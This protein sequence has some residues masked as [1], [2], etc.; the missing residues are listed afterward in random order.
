MHAAIEPIWETAENAIEKHEEHLKLMMAKESY[1][2]VVAEAE[3]IMVGFSTL[4]LSKRPEVFLKK[5]SASIQETYV[6]SEYRKA[7]IGKQ[8]AQALISIAREKG[9]EMITLNVAVDNE[10]GNIFWKEM[11][12]R[13]TV[14]QM[15]MYLV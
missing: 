1:H 9:V 2:I 5:Q 4:S 11:G 10:V 14:N 8:L 3:N 7:G 13:P 12:F 15:A 6:R